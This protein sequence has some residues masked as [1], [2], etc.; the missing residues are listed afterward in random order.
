MST[1]DYS[2]DYPLRPGG[3]PNMDYV[4]EIASRSTEA[5]RPPETVETIEG[6]TIAEAASAFGLSVSSIR[7]LLKAGKLKGA[8]KIPGAKGSEYRIPPASLEALGYKAKATQSGAVLTAAR[9]NLEAE[10]LTAKVAELQ[11]S[12]ELERVRRESAEK[13][14]QAVSANLNDL[15]EVIAKL[16]PAIEPPQKRKLFRRSS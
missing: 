4:R 9:A 8:A 15:R 3:V 5:S 16:P 13:E 11:A 1:G 14:L 12:L 6:L 7:R 10:Q 2:H